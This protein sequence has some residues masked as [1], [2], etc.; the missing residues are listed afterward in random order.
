[1]L[2][3]QF[4]WFRRLF[5][6]YWRQSE[7]PP[8]ASGARSPEATHRNI[9]SGAVP[10]EVH[11]PEFAYPEP[12]LE[13]HRGPSR[14]WLLKMLQQ[15]HCS[16]RSPWVRSRSCRWPRHSVRQKGHREVRDGVFWKT[17][18]NF[19]LVFVAVPTHQLVHHILRVAEKFST[20][21]LI[22]PRLLSF[23]NRRYS[24]I[25]LAVHAHSLIRKMLWRASDLCICCWKKRSS[26]SYEFIAC[27]SHA[28]ICRPGAFARDRL[29]R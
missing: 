21:H 17:V 16:L 14:T 1:M 29:R 8:D 10:V 27:W 2:I 24:W 13:H 26:S 4:L 12:R 20:I 7:P 6:P 23:E 25:S 22:L 5:F 19:L 9:V 3:V 15:L 18:K 28:E 11:L